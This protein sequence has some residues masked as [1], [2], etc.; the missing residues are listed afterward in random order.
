MDSK[1]FLS[2]FTTIVLFLIIIPFVCSPPPNPPPTAPVITGPTIGNLDRDWSEHKYT[3]SIRGT[4][5]EPIKYFI[6]WSG[7]PWG[8]YEFLP[9]DYTYVNSGTTLSTQHGWTNSG[10][11]TF[12][13]Y[14]VS[15]LGQIS[16]PTSYT[17]Y[18]AP[19]LQ[20]TVDGDHRVIVGTSTQL[21][22]S[23][24]GGMTVTSWEWEITN[25]DADCILDNE[26][27]PTPTITCRSVNKNT[28]LA[29]T[30]TDS[31]GSTSTDTSI[32]RTYPVPTC[33]VSSII[34][35]PMRSNGW[36]QITVDYNGFQ[37]DPQDTSYVNDYISCG[38]LTTRYL[39][40]ESQY[41][42]YT[43]D[44]RCY[45]NYCDYSGII[46]PQSLSVGATLENYFYSGIGFTRVQQNI[47]CT[48]ATINFPINAPPTLPSIVRT[49]TGTAK[50]GIPQ[51][52]S[53]TSTDPEGDRIRYLIDWNG[54]SIYDEIIPANSP[55]T[56]TL[57]SDMLAH[58]AGEVNTLDSLGSYN[59]TPCCSTLNN[60]TYSEGVI[61]HSFY[62]NSTNS[63]LQIPNNAAFNIGANPFGIDAWIR[64]TSSNFQYIFSKYTPTNPS[65]GYALAININDP[66]MASTCAVGNI[67]FYDGTTW[68]GVASGIKTNEWTHVAF[69]RPG[70]TG[71]NIGVF[72][73][74]GVNKGSIN[75]SA[76]ISA[77]P[78]PAYIGSSSVPNYFFQGYIDEVH[79]FS[80]F[81][82]FTE[83]GALAH[84]R[85][86]PNF[87]PSGTTVTGTYT[88]STP[89]SKSFNVFTED[90]FNF[91]KSGWATLGLVLDQGPTCSINPSGTI[92]SSYDANVDFDVTVSAFTGTITSL[93]VSAKCYSLST[94]D[95]NFRNIVPT[96]NTFLM[97]CSNYRTDGNITATIVGN[98]AGEKAVC[99]SNV[100]IGLSANAGADILTA[101]KVRNSYNSVALNGVAQGGSGLYTYAW[102]IETDVN[103]ANPKCVLTN[104]T[105]FVTGF[106]CNIDAAMSGVYQARVKFTVTD[107]VGNTASDYVI[108]SVTYPLV[109]PL[110][111]STTTPLTGNIDQN[112]RLVGEI[113]TYGLDPH[114]FLWVFDTSPS[115]T[116]NCTIYDATTLTPKVYCA[117]LNAN[118]V[119]KL[120]LT[121]TDNAFQV[122]YGY[123]DLNV[124]DITCATG[125]TCKPSNTIF[126]GEF[127]TQN[128]CSINGEVKSCYQKGYAPVSSDVNSIV[129]LGG[130]VVSGSIEVT[131]MCSK[132]T[133]AIM[134]IEDISQSIPVQQIITLPA[135]AIVSCDVTPTTSILTISPPITN[136]AVI[137]AT[138][139]IVS[140]APNC[141]VCEQVAFINYTAQGPSTTIPDNSILVVLVALVFVVVLLSK[142]SK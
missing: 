4:D 9:A 34:P 5:T 109:N 124:K 142:R 130:K 95:A 140:S 101:A 25:N 81:L 83:V 60:A 74:N 126:N 120:K 27:T 3:F 76:T 70:N 102:V 52:F 137:K 42:G 138:A 77:S 45:N 136:E 26:T 87:S 63:Y 20:V 31:L 127:E 132:K 62:M 96:G 1:R 104:P 23:T 90:D 39:D 123:V 56:A 57:P 71:T 141:T 65:F 48:P 112:I 68:R 135:S 107:S 92:N 10:Y 75:I 115:P 59:H 103:P 8:V 86:T 82:N 111:I 11:N 69:T 113:D 116:S 16:T 28:F 6:V 33:N 7:N 119:K 12:K 131:L 128:K 44:G 18:I 89:G 41:N 88:W 49:T 19:D 129:S 122:K 46:H 108:V 30:V 110:S 99:S 58:W 139:S 15:A 79:L 125:S 35:N 133:T 134:K 54:D 94:N 114:E 13:A 121:V 55:S 100:K 117:G 97:R 98:V 66:T 105:N 91:A 84:N 93:N 118:G 47:T 37:S 17:I 32:I 2:V 67:C 72:Y 53:I 43:Y 106:Y 61:G 50:T 64:P 21:S 29:V 80:K 24:T 78:N 36:A 14:T 22:A 38:N 73:V 40:C 51:S 85:E